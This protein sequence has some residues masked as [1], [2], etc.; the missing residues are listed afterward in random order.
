MWFVPK[1]DQQSTMHSRGEKKN[2]HQSPKKVFPTKPKAWFM[3]PTGMIIHLAICKPNHRMSFL[4]KKRNPC[5]VT[6]A[7]KIKSFVPE[8]LCKQKRFVGSTSHEF[9]FW[10]ILSAGKREHRAIL[11]KD[12]SQNFFGMQCS[13]VSLCLLCF[14]SA[15]TFSYIYGWYV[16]TV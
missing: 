14:V 2:W 6:C 12:I 4:P 8:S 13:K 1:I 16:Y 11:P 15:F 9:F 7:G 3:K 5:K 10:H